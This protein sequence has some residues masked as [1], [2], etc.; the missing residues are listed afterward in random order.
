MKNVCTSRLAQPAQSDSPR[1]YM[2]VTIMYRNSYDG[3]DGWIYH[4][5]KITI[6]DTCPRCGQKR[7]QPRP[8]TFCEDGEWFT[9]DRW[10]NACG[11]VDSYR[12]A[13]LEA[14]EVAA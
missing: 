13:Y 14:K 9:V 6:A 2:N 10:V 5:L 3:G 12:N 1:R 4:P 8:H 11:H 7:G